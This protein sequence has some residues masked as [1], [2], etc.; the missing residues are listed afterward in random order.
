MYKIH[1]QVSRN[2]MC[3][4]KDN[5]FTIQVSL[6]DGFNHYTALNCNYFSSLTI[7]LLCI[8]DNWLEAE[9]IRNTD[10]KHKTMNSANSLQ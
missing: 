10:L 3:S 6:S 8:T 1:V 7:S 2:Q 4:W 9:Y 5:E